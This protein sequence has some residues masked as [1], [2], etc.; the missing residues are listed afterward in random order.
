MPSIGK[1]YNNGNE[2]LII[3]LS[4]IENDLLIKAA[5][6]CNYDMLFSKIFFMTQIGTYNINLSDILKAQ[7]VN[8]CF[9]NRFE[10][11]DPHSKKSYRDLLLRPIKQEDFK[12]EMDSFIDKMNFILNAIGCVC[13]DCEPDKY[14]ISPKIETKHEEQLNYNS[15]LKNNSIYR[16]HVILRP[17]IDLYNSKN[18]SQRSGD[19][20]I[21]QR[22][23]NNIR[24]L[25]LWQHPD[26]MALSLAKYNA[27]DTFDPHQYMLTKRKKINEVSKNIKNKTGKDL[28]KLSLNL[29]HDFITKLAREILNKNYNEI[30]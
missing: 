27:V 1:C 9:N 30:L 8:Y 5:S 12:R 16:H 26:H 7:M 23:N 25:F 13:K 17:E 10:I 14:G 18:R 2:F 3:E 21:Y 29:H 19:W 15:F 6:I 22:K 20:L 28:N 11:Y 24:F 4:E